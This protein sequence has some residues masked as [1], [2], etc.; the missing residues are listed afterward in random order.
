MTTA[1]HHKLAAAAPL[2]VPLVAVLCAALVGLSLIALTSESAADAIAAFFDGAFGS[3]YAI[4]ASLN[5][6]SAL[7]LVGLGFIVANR[8]NLT[9]VGGEGQIAVGGITATAIALTPG[10]AV[11]PLGLAFVLPLMAAAVAGAAWG[12][13]AGILKVRFGAN[14]V[15]TTLLLSFVAVSLIYWSVDATYFLRQPMTASD[16]LPQ[17]LEIAAASKLP[18]LTSNPAAPLHLG[19]LLTILAAVTVAVMLRYSA[20]STRLKAV[21]LNLLAARRAGMACG[22]L[23]I[24]A[25]ATAGAF[26]G[27]AGGLMLLGEQHLLKNGFSSGYGFDGLVVGLLSRGSAAGVVVG[28]LFFGFLR[29]GGINMEISAGVPSAVV[30]IMQGLIVVAVA[31]AALLL[32]RIEKTKP[33]KQT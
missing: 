14:E 7:A 9:N 29:S 4:S 25:L 3:A 2:L 19:I 18:L 11:L 32:E 20:L 23:L 8:C 31:G 16:T 22:A 13:I 15:I 26:G 10:V 33:S 27:A 28:A 5:R 1:M 6:A 30:L 24:G 21:G 17:S 12:A